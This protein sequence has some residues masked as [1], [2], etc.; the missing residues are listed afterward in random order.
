MK[1]R[2]LILAAAAAGYA[3]AAGVAGAEGLLYRL[4]RTAT[5]P[6]TDTWWDYI[7]MEPEGDRLFMARVAD[8]LTVFDTKA[9]KALGTVANST[10]ANGPL[11]LPEYDR[12]YVAMT[13]GSLLSFELGSLKVIERLPLDKDGGLN[14]AILDP[15][16]GQVHAI[17]GTRQKEATWYTLDAATGKLLKTTSFPF[18]KMDDPASDG[19]GHLFAPARYDDVILKLDSRNLEEQDRWS[20]G[21]HVSK[22]RYQAHTNRLLAACTGDK[23]TFV[24]FDATTGRE[25]ARLPIGR[26]LD[27]LVVDDKRRRIVTSNGIDGTLTVIGQ[28]GPDSY[29]LLGTVSTRVGARMMDLDNQTGRLFVVAADYTLG[30]PDADGEESETYHPDSFVV[31]TYRPE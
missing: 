22:V 13:D 12:G 19:K 2:S 10:G 24:A 5:L 27:A 9:N 1:I 26:G 7:K 8:G 14:S 31:L 29:R 11:L 20:V 4:E 15:A 16:T 18:R 21:C 25:V 17:V 28:D 30:A 3:L 6:S 23:P